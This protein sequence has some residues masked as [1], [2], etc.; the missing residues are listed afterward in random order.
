VPPGQAAGAVE[1]YRRSLAIAPDLVAAVNGL[2]VAL[3]ALGDLRA[4]S[5]A[6]RAGV[7]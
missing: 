1:A 7:S 5:E 3:Q 6:L 2:G 4:A